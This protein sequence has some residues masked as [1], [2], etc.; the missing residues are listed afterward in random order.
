MKKTLIITN[1]VTVIL[2][3]LVIFYAQSQGANARM[4]FEQAKAESTE[5][6]AKAAEMAA[7]TDKARSELAECMSISEPEA[8]D[9][10]E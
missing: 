5:C 4:A 1:I 3:V 8:T 10:T 2:L 6:S 9:P 7:A